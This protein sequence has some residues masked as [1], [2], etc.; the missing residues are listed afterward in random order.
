MEATVEDMVDQDMA[1]GL[2]DRDG[3]AKHDAL[4]RMKG[5]RSCQDDQHSYD[6]LARVLREDSASG[7]STSS[8][9]A[10]LQLS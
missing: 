4:E 6:I 3:A 5:M 2:E 7:V 8:V 10:S 9:S 1:E